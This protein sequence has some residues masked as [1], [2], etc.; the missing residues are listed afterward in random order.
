M[1]INT[2]VKDTTSVKGTSKTNSRDLES[3][4]NNQRE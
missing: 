3:R 4:E 2:E 1:E